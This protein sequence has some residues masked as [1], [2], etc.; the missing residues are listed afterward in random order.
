M[1]AF[2]SGPQVGTAVRLASRLSLRFELSLL[3]AT[4]ARTTVT[5]SNSTDS[6]SIQAAN[7]LQA[8]GAFCIVL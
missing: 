2:A 6:Y 7:F 5:S 8:Y 3:H 1:D 4:P